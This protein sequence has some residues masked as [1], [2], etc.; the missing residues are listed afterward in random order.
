MGIARQAGGIG[1]VTLREMRRL[2][3]DL[4]HRNQDWFD[5]QPFM[6]RDPGPLPPFASRAFTVAT[7][8]CRA[9]PAHVLLPAAHLAALYVQEP[10]NPAWDRY[11]W[12]SDTDLWGQRVYVGGVSNTGRFEIHRHL[13]ITDRWGVPLWSAA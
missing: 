5:A 12:T 11:L 6:D 3:P 10:E 8:D 13:A 1:G 2:Y 4:F 7:A 9:L